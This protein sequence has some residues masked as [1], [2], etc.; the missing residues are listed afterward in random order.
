MKTIQFSSEGL[1]LDADIFYPPNMITGNKYP[2]ILFVHG[3]ISSRDRSYQYAESLASLGYVCI[4]FDMRG[5]G[6]SQGDRLELSSKDFLN[7]V[8]V[9]YDYLANLP[10]VD[11]ENISANGGLFGKERCQ[12]SLVK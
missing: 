8:L 4:V 6:T 1:R 5:H 2:A 3:W 11:S 9:A 10:E 12:K 7:D